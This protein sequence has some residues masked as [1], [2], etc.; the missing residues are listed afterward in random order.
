M[1]SHDL[2]TICCCLALKQLIICV[3]V[4]V[5]KIISKKKTAK[6]RAKKLSHSY[7]VIQNY[8]YV[9]KKYVWY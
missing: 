5:L 2:W 8:V 9:Y 1:T 4:C 7:F 3:C 6:S